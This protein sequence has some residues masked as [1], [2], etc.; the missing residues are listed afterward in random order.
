MKK[1]YL[2]TSLSF[3]IFTATISGTPGIIHKGQKSIE[4]FE[5]T[6]NL[7]DQKSS[8]TPIKCVLKEVTVKYKIAKQEGMPVFYG[9]IKYSQ[10]PSEP[11]CK[12]PS[13]TVIWLHLYNTDLN[14]KVLAKVSTGASENFNVWSNEVKESKTW[15]NSF[16]IE[17][18]GIDG[19]IAVQQEKAKKFWQSDNIKVLKFHP[20]WGK[21]DI[22][23]TGKLT[24]SAV[25]DAFDWNHAK[26][27]CEDMEMRLPTRKEIEYASE[28]KLPVLRRSGKYGQFWTSETKGDNRVYVANFMNGEYLLTRQSDTNVELRCVKSD[29]FWPF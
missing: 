4:N 21:T 22:V 25:A 19:K 10:N 18:W 1:I 14:R 23:K 16:W 20:G 17:T 27:I 6:S 24:W 8:Y 7:Y 15:L 2:A 5:Y 26:Q 9:S 29:G 28:S 12:L 13:S 11:D 3:L